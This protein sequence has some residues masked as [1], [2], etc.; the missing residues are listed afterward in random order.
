MT[1]NFV[2]PFLIG[3]AL[4]AAGLFGLS[5][6]HAAT[7]GDPARGAQVY[8]GKCTGCHSLDTNRVGPAHRGVFGRKAGLAA[9]YSYSAGVRTSRIVWNEVTLDR[10][11][12]DP[13]ATIAGARMGFRLADPGQRADVI[14]YLRQ[15]SAVRR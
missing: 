5:P 2:R 10:W 6:S 13:Q 8:G 4:G 14:A 15:Q 11:L 1:Q 12:T 7:V 3:F 9:G